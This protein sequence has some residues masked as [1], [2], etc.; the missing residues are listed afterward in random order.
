[1]SSIF[2]QRFWP[3]ETGPVEKLNDEQKKQIAFMQIAFENGF[4]PFSENYD[5]SFE[6]NS[7]SRTAIMIRRY[8]VNVSGVVIPSPVG[9]AML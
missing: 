6:A 8:R 9:V 5:S 7:A 1:M 3:Y 4:A 2:T